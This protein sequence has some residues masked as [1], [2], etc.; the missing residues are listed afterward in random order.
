MWVVGFHLEIGFFKIEKDDGIELFASSHQTMIS[1][2][3]QKALERT[4]WPLRTKESESVKKRSDQYLS[5]KKIKKRKNPLHKK[6]KR[7]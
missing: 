1:F 5:M 2:I 4:F 3:Q 7:V 6:T